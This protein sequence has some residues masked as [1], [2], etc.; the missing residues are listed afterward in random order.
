MADYHPALHAA[1]AAN[2]ALPEDLALMV[3]RRADS[4]T[5]AEIY[6]NKQLFQRPRVR[7]ALLDCPQAPAVALLEIVN[8]LGDLGS[9]LSVLSN[10]KIRALEVKGKARSRLAERFRSMSAGEKVAAV[11][12]GGRRLLK[13]LWSDFFRDEAL[14]LKCLQEKQLDEGTVLEIARS[15]ISPRRALEVIGNNPGWVS[16]YQITLSLVLNPKTP[17]Q[18][19]ARLMR[20]LNPADRKMVKNNPALPQSIRQMA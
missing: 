5:A 4:R 20:K 16:N 18:V 10:P 3:T 2:P 11:R 6:R 12:R 8:H 17:R 19:V 15:K 1:L 13:E 9:L 7:Q 14:V